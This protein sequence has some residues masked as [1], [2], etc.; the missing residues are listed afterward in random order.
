MTVSIGVSSLRSLAAPSSDA[1]V[2]VA[3][4]RQY[5]AKRN[6]RNQVVARSS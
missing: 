5:A 4:E 3:D 2:A 1:L 6:G